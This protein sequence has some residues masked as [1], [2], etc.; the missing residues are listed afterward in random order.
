MTTKIDIK[1]VN[2]M[3]G[4][5]QEWL[6][7]HLKNK[8]A[9]LAHLQVALEEYQK[10]G[11]RESFML[12]LRHVAMAQGGV[13]HLAKETHLNRESLYRL[14]SGKGNPTIETLLSIL[15]VFGIRIKLAAA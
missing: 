12:S 3:T 4:D 15:R 11:D 7:S 13:A 9:A 8:K 10:D 14:L 1:K 2:E 5:Y 6:I